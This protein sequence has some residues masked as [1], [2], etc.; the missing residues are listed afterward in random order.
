M[1]ETGGAGSGT[2]PAAR[3][4]FDQSTINAARWLITGADGARFRIIVAWLARPTRTGPTARRCSSATDRPGSHLRAGGEHRWTAPRPGSRRGRVPRPR[5]PASRCGARRGGLV[6][7]RYYAWRC[8]DLAWLTHCMRWLGA[9]SRAHS[10]V[11]HA[12]TCTGSSA[13]PLSG[14]HQGVGFMLADNETRLQQCRLIWWACWALNTGPGRHE[15]L[16]VGVRVRGEQIRSKAA[17]RCV[18][19]LGGM[20][21]RRDAG[22]H[23]LRHARLPAL[24][25]PT[26]VH[27]VMR[28]P[29]GAEWVRDEGVLTRS[30]DRQGE[31]VVTGVLRTGV[32]PAGLR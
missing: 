19:I 15:S 27:K 20:G 11:D 6:A 7:L 12:C 24:R 1:T 5:P 3:R 21:I 22:R 30:I 8:G 17:D 28:S 9:A 2:G 29:P 13:K 25:M 14:E 18:Q 32:S 16:T 23:D 31:F 4:A 10:T 26:E